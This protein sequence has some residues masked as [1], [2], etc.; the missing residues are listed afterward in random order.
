MSAYTVYQKAFYAQTKKCSVLLEAEFHINGTNSLRAG[1]SVLFPLLHV[2]RRKMKQD[3]HV[4][5]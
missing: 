1:R 5:R 3:V 2:E 4:S